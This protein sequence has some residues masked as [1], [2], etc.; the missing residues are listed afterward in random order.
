VTSARTNTGTNTVRICGWSG[1]R[2]L[3]TA[4]MRA[5]ENRA[6]CAVWDE[7]FYGAYLAATGIEHPGRDEVLA[8][9]ETNPVAVARACTGEPP[10]AAGA[11]SAAPLYYQKHMSQHMLPGVDLTWTDASR[12]IFLIRDPAEVIASFAAVRETP[13]LDEIGVLRQRE[14]F[15]WIA[16]RQGRPP[17][18]IDAKDLRNDPDAILRALC[19]ALDVPFDAAMLNWPAGPRDSDGVWAPWWYASVERSTGFTP[20]E[21]SRHALPEELRPLVDACLPHYAAMRAVALG[22]E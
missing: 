21:P 5:W 9:T 22:A 2:N 18:V 1:P 3:S 6:D 19:A 16:K 11:P 17:P 12:H 4:L 14:L 8:A 20:W 13:T 15:D 7:P 10:N